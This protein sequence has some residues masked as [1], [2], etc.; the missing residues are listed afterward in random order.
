MD[1]IGEG[2]GEGFDM[3]RRGV[4]MLG[5]NVDEGRSDDDAVGNLSD[6]RGLFGGADA[7]AD[8]D[9]QVGGGFEA[10]DGFIDARLRRL[11]LAGDPGDRAL[12]EDTPRAV[13]PGGA[14]RGGGG[15][16]GGAAPVGA[17]AP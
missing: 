7:E 9:G 16:G 12:I 5:D 13:P 14:A 17:G 15:R 6:L 8:R 11:L 2:A 3:R 10:C 4:A 1:S